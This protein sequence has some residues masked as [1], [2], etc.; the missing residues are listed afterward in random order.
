M[1][2][3]RS[4]TRTILEPLAVAIVLAVAVRS[5]VHVYS[6]PSSSMAP[7]LG[8]GDHILVARYLGRS[9]GRGDVVVFE[10]PHDR[11][12]LLV[13]RIVA[14]PGDLV[15]TRLG[16]VRIGGH[17]LPEPY[18]LRP[19]TTGAIEPRIVPA[20][21]YYVLGDNREESID[22]RSFG[23]VP[24]SSIVGRARIVLCSSRFQADPARAAVGGDA[25]G[26]PS[27]PRRTRRLFKWVR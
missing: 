2:R 5:V 7:A 11:S 25:G 27:L 19:A 20:D 23:P 17:T 14:V 6:I 3:Q 26:D 1:P 9:P 15:D 22:S 16:Q 24:A 13:K 21:S 8:T 10:S 12:E 4:L 18:L